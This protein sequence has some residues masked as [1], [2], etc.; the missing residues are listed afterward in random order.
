MTRDYTFDQGFAQER[1]RLSAMEALWDP[2]SQALLDELGVGDGWRCLEVGAGGGSL[3]Q[4]MAGRGAHVT[5]IDID[6]RFVD[7][8]A[9]GQIEVRRL[10]LR[11]DELPR[12]Q[13]DLVHARLVLEHLNDRRQILDR[14][15]AALRPGGWIVIEDYDWS[16]FGFEEQD[17]SD[18]AVGQAIL[19]FMEKAGFQRDYGRKIVADLI[20][21]GLTD[22]RGEGRA[23]VVAPG[24][25]G[26][27]FFRLSFESLRGALVDAGELAVSDAESASSRFDGD[28]RVFTPLMVTGIGRSR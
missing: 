19:A 1:R 24:E 27:D 9:S 5:A 26:F 12:A 20:D 4:W 16:C 28:V 15:A 7:H 23:R 2:G 6:T 3:V 18:D 10:D 21:A 8:L 25:P 13:F 11:T 17:D 22:V 14:L